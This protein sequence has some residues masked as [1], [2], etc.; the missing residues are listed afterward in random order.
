[1]S[2]LPGTKKNR[3]RET[4][5]ADANSER[6]APARSYS[7]DLPE[8]ANVAGYEYETKQTLI[9]IS[10][11]ASVLD[12]GLHRDSLG[13]LVLARHDVDVRHVDPTKSVNHERRL[14]GPSFIHDSRCGWYPRARTVPPLL[15]T[16]WCCN[17]PRPP[18]RCGFG[19]PPGSGSRPTQDPETASRPGPFSTPRPRWR[20]TRLRPR[21]AQVL[22]VARWGPSLRWP[23]I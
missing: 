13:E 20:E 14:S 16:V 11:H 2:W 10:L 15:K 4:F 1:M 3:S 17:E 21:R 8:N 12:E 7:S 23:E 18:D 9:A 19:R 22:L 6:K 5:R